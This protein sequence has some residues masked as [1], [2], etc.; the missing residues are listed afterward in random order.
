MCCFCFSTGVS[1]EIPK[2]KDGICIVNS[3]SGNSNTEEI[4]WT[5]KQYKLRYWGRRKPGT[6]PWMCGFPAGKTSENH[7]IKKKHQNEGL[8][9]QSPELCPASSKKRAA[10]SHPSWKGWSHANEAREQKR[11][12]HKPHYRT[13]VPP[14]QMPHHPNKR[15]WGQR[16]PKSLDHPRPPPLSASLRP[17][18]G[19]VAP[20]ANLPSVPGNWHFF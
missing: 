12:R 6:L 10:G 7:S 1:E 16:R 9:S 5:W 8:E 4:I 11:P 15:V 3:L 19:Q 13:A 14:Q 20:R 2:S 17:Q 18:R